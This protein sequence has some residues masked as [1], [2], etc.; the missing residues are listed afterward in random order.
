MAS[1]SH[2]VSG[3]R[4][5]NRYYLFSIDVELGKRVEAT[6]YGSYRKGCEKV[7]VRELNSL[8]KPTRT[9]SKLIKAS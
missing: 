9:S 8:K 3:D 7:Y 1:K 4:C 2:K 5:T 6:D